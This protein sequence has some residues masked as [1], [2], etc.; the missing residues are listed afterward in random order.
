[1]RKGFVSLSADK[2]IGRSMTN[3]ARVC[4]HMPHGAPIG[5]LSTPGPRRDV[6][7]VTTAIAIG[8]SS[9]AE[10]ICTMAERSAQMD[11]P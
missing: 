3:S 6:L 2:R 4:R 10:I 1:M 9:P 11:N 7:G 8:L 5:G